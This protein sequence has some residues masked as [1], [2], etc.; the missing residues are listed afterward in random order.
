MFS[1]ILPP[2]EYSESPHGFG[3]GNH[4]TVNTNT[5]AQDNE[6][7]PYIETNKNGIVHFKNDYAHALAYAKKTGKPLM[8]DFTGHA[9]ANCRKTEDYVWPDAEVTKRLNN[10]VV[11]V[12]L[13][14]D[15][16]RALEQKDYMKVFWYGKEREITD[17]GDKFKYMEETLYGQSTQPLYVLLDHNEKLLNA[18][19]GYDPSIPDYIKWMDEGI[20]KFKESKK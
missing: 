17:I 19:R 2:L 13:Y 6:F 5:S 12:S 20:A 4:Q 11:L 15:D 1:G 7:A 16:K 3:G 18:V 9:C 10:D 14:V 8:V